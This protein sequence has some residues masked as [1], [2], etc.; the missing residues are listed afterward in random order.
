MKSI[1]QFP[2]KKLAIIVLLLTG[3]MAFS[4]QDTPIVNQ[5][6]NE[7]KSTP[8]TIPSL[9]NKE[10]LTIT[11][12]NSMITALNGSMENLG[13]S[14]SS[15]NNDLVRQNALAAL[16]SIDMGKMSDQIRQSLQSIDLEK[17]FDQANLA[18]KNT[19]LGPL[20]KE[21]ALA[22]EEAGKEMQKAKA[23]LK[24]IN[25]AEIDKEMKT[26]AKELEKAK[27][28]IRKIDVKKIMA[29]ADA[30]VKK[31]N[32]EMNQTS[33]LFTALEKDGLINTKDGF[34]IRYENKQLYVNG[35]K[36]SP[37]VTERYRRYFNTDKFEITISA[38][39]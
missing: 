12:F 29:E 34:N 31:A 24:S 10:A 30:E 37:S 8:D 1:F 32:M 26:A 27:A 23:E 5:I 22:I 39:K 35:I 15:L 11:E 36:Q 33:A 17:V 38:E 3:C 2:T 21:L 25:Y 16:E 13:I 18:I 7:R 19:E 20:N 4:F 6:L 28:E 14:L 9:K